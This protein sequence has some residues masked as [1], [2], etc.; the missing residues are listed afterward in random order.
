M[1]MCKELD[2]KTNKILSLISPQKSLSNF[3][4]HFY[5]HD[6]KDGLVAALLMQFV[7]F[8]L[9]LPFQCIQYEQYKRKRI[10]THTHTYT[11]YIYHSNFFLKPGQAIGK[12]EILD[13]DKHWFWCLSGK[14]SSWGVGCVG[15]FAHGHK[16]TQKR[17]PDPQIH[18]TPPP[19][20][21]KRE[22][23]TIPLVG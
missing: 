2:T 12:G 9:H 22:E 8:S 14:G 13:V 17:W 4:Y 21:K 6:A 23:K 1:C 20:T 18:T 15:V 11:I 10:H 5:S 16:K 19:A 3:F 7:W